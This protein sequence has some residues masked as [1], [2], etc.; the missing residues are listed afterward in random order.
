[1]ATKYGYVKRDP[2]DTQLNWSQI[3]TDVTDMLQNEVKV[4][5]EKKAA[6]DQA[7]RDYQEILNNVPQGEN[8]QLNEFSLNAAEKL[9][10]QMLM[11]ETLLKSGQ[12]NPKQYTI[13]RQN[14]QDGTDQAF[15]LLQDYND[16]Y[17]EKMAMM[18][19]DLPVSER[20]SQMQTWMMEQ[21]EGFANFTQTE[22]VI[23]PETGI[24]SMAKLIDDGRGNL[25]PD[26]NPNNLVTVQQLRNRIKT[27]YTQY[28]VIGGADEFI[29]T[30]GTES[31]II[32]DLGNKYKAG[33]FKK[34]KDIRDREG[35]F[36][37]KTPAELATL[38]KEMGIQPNELKAYSLFEQSQLTYINGQLSNPNFAASV[39]LD[40]VGETFDKKDYVPTFDPEEAKNDPSKILLKSINGRVEAQLTDEQKK[41]AVE[42]Y[43]AQIDIGLD[44]EETVQVSQV[45]REPR[46]LTSDE[47]QAGERRRELDAKVSKIADLYKGDDMA[48]QGATDY[49]RD[50][51][52]NIQSVTRDEDGIVV[53][54]INVN[55]GE[56]EERPVSFYVMEDNPAFDDT[57]DEGP[58]N[59]RRIKKLY[60]ATQADVDAG[61]ASNI[62]EMIPKL[63]SQA[64]FIESAGPLLTGESDISRAL[65]RGGYEKGA[66]FN[67]EAT[68]SSKVVKQDKATIDYSTDIDRW[69]S[70]LVEDINFGE[71]DFTKE[72]GGAMFKLDENEMGQRIVDKL[73]NIEG[74]E[75]VR[76]QELDNDKISLSLPG[77][78][79]K[80]PLVIEVKFRFSDDDS[81]KN[82]NEL[83]KWIMA[84]AS[85]K[86]NQQKFI[87]SNNWKG[88][89]LDA[90]GIPM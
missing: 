48:I 61:L 13:M 45:Y 31:K 17:A 90:N 74:I 33:I 3:A 8:T 46:P 49:F 64:E 68:T 1:M 22:L 85:D 9:Q 78:P 70:D 83:R 16:E 54:Y 37:D 67:P 62:G 7:T 19:P 36:K 50:Q 80:D 23:N 72:N 43:K 82:L 57:K 63:K 14:L 5:E 10:K 6:I 18:S 52:D 73:N 66:K 42:A 60:E 88:Q 26:P 71:E 12:L 4:R 35:G 21:V 69:A 24:M 28:D 39:L 51:N 65:S 32:E 2:Q 47:R 25:I 15:G 81:A 34:I 79:Q 44:Y 38:A 53:T 75:G 58:G 77:H 20:A 11:Q 41:V 27:K 55:T 76:Y 86:K 30:L 40:F 59:E 84:Y 29:N 89:K 87:D 56:L